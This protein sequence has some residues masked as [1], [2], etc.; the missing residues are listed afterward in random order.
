VRHELFD[1]KP[2]GGEIGILR[3]QTPDA[4]QVV[5][6]QDHGQS[7]KWTVGTNPPHHIAQGPGHLGIGQPWMPVMGDQREKKTAPWHS[8]A[9]VLHG[10]PSTTA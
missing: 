7:F 4:V 2:S 5:G 1:Q 10:T 6:H 8:S 3:G 9:T